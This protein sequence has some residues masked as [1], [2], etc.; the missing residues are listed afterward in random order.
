MDLK[1][2]LV[3][4]ILPVYNSSKF[5][6]DCLESLNR[7]SYKNIQI[8]AID[9]F[10]KDN[11]VK[12]LQKFKKTQK[13]FLLLK[14]K[15]HYGPAI[16]YNR[17]IK[18]AQGQF[19][20]FMNPNDKAAANRIKRQVQFLLANPKTVAVGTQ[21][22]RIDDKGKKIEKSELPLEHELIYHR[23]LPAASFQPETA[24]INRMLLP[25]DLLYFQTNKYPFLFTEVFVKLLQYGQLANTTDALY[26]RRDNVR[27]HGRKQSKLKHLTSVFQIWLKS[28]TNY[29]YR[30]SL[31]S[32][33][34]PLVKSA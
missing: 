10:S 1:P 25:K 12:L 34:T 16:C 17:A 13:N 9:D 29:D 30:P 8:I 27:R 18:Y 14:N 15:K 4:I 2:Y 19:L 22:T 31:R 23:L 20:A 21:F 3:T 26:Y 11:T 32:V 24:M 7:Q 5:L 33:F 28:R 6:V